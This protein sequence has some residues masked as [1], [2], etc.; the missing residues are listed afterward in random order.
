[1]D[2]A[3]IAV[4]GE[5]GRVVSVVLIDATNKVRLAIPFPDA[6]IVRSVAFSP[7]GKT[8]AASGGSTTRLFDTATGQERVKID[9]KS[10]GL[11]F[12][13]DGAILVGA[14]AGTIYRW[15]AATGKSLIPEGGD[16]PVAQ[17]AV[18]ADGKRVVSLGQDGDAH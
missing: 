14:V 7:D 2:G 8:V 13:P 5:S 9:R 17:V 6:S 11:T 1:A 4:G 12:S 3:T 15:D 18:T 10:I 16:S